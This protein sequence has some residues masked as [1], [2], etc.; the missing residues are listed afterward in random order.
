[1][2]FTRLSIALLSAL[3]AV[4]ARESNSKLMGWGAKAVGGEGGMVYHVST[5]AEFKEALQNNGKPNE[6]KIIYVDGPISANVDEEGKTLTASDYMTGFNFDDY[7]NCFTEDGTTWLDTEECNKINELRLA[8]APLQKENIYVNVTPYT[9]IIGSGD[10]SKL[11]DMS[12]QIQSVDQ[13]IIKDLYVQAPRDFFAEWDPTDGITGSWNAEYDAIVVNNSTNVWVDSCY[14][15]D[16]EYSNNTTKKVFGKFIEL[17][18]GLLDIV[19]SA[20]FV[21]VS[22]NRFE[23]H[24]KTS[25]LGNSDKRVTDAGH[26]KVTF[27]NNVYIHCQERLPR[28]RFGKVHVFNNYY[29]ASTQDD[30][31][32]SLTV[33]NY[34][35][36]DS[37]FPNYMIG[38]GI[39]SNILSEYNSF[40][41]IGNEKIPA[42]EDI[43]VYSYGGHVFRDNGSEFNGKNIDLTT[44]AEESF[45][46]KVKTKMAQNAAAGK[47]NPDWVNATFSSETFEPSEFYD[48]EFTKNLDDVNDLINKVPYWLFD[49]DE[50]EQTTIA[51]NES[52]DEEDINGSIDNDDEDSNDEEVDIPDMEDDDDS[53]DEY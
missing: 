30:D 36:D 6:P 14:L 25:L 39:E 12:I 19:D 42:S 48:Y 53:A 33:N 49:N 32:P 46:L 29:L 37:V 5:F 24:A 40:N 23:N 51:D 9:T 45:K 8:G 7:L 43:V 11:V 31:Y 10:S 35:H 18:D 1:M 38:L 47:A 21:T 3:S 16:G 44:L 26:I 34:Y 22:N 20:D 28:V 41:Y 27:Y 50:P 17:H 4:S 2:K 13:V 52:D 15:T